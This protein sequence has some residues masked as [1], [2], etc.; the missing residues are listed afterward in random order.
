MKI[1]PRSSGRL[2]AALLLAAAAAQGAHAQAPRPAP[3][4][5][6]FKLPP[7]RTTA[8]ITAAD[9]ASRVYILADDSMMGREAGTL[10]NI[11]GNDYVARELRRLGLEPAGDN[12]TYFQAIPLVRRGPGAS[13]SLTVDGAALTQWTDFAP[14]PFLP[15]VFNYGPRLATSNTQ[16][17]YGGRI[18]EA[19][20]ITPEQAAG[21]LVVF[22][23]PAG[24]SGP[25]FRF[26]TRGP[27][28]KFR[29][30]AGVAIATLDISPPGIVG[31]FRQ[32][33][34][35]LAGGEP[36]KNQGPAGVIVTRA[37]A[38]R[39][40]GAPLD[41]LTP[42][43]AGKTVSGTVE[44]LDEP[45]EH[46]A[47]NVVA[48]LRGSDPR[49]RSEYVAIGSHNDHDGISESAVDHDSLRVHNRFLRPTGADMQPTAAGPE[50]AARIRAAL[51]SLR[52]LRGVRRDSV[53]NGADDDASG[54][55]AMLEIAEAL[56]AQRVKP[57]RSILF[58]WHTAEEKGLLGSEW[59]SEHPTVPRDS[60]VA[61]LNLDMVGRGRPGDLQGGGP[62]Y[63][64]LVGSRRLSTELGDL[65]E[66]VN[67]ERGHNF[68]FD[69]SMDAD[70]HPDNIYCRSDHYNYA[71][72]GIPV[73]FFTTGGHP[74]YHMV[75]DEPQYIDAEK[76]AKVSSLVADVTRAIADRDARL[77]V[78][79][80]KPDP[81][82][83]CRQ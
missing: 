64:Q 80:P 11:K 63:V 43:A 48:I 28:D 25:D 72:W 18:G 81:Y 36:P 76:L 59:Y 56:A 39:L 42:G 61:Q 69:Y 10:G 79:K 50:Q 14:I 12:G 45:V 65:V 82:G 13:S 58:V 26:W 22:A 57:K 73:T 62:A 9:A 17:V 33:Q 34:M 49:L 20:Q 75:T 44:F 40:L 16:V 83:A 51:D 68:R 15:G 6:P 74:E 67:T 66:R 4:E 2:G 29:G 27:L 30:A 78:D 54:M 47:R 31:F 71:R 52:A 32:E 60:I 3:G 41:G 7:A 37:V 55:T 53:Y 1:A 8:A 77:T 19:N 46:P 38:E 23:A 21:K 70:G 35:V 5:G 24:A